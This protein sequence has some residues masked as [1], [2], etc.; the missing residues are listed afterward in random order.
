[1][2]SSSDML[3]LSQKKLF[4]LTKIS[5]F[6]SLY[7]D[8]YKTKWE[9][10]C[11]RACGLIVQFAIN[12][13]IVCLPMQWKY[14]SYTYTRA[15]NFSWYCAICIF[16]LILIAFLNRCIITTGN[17]AHSIHF[18]SFIC[19]ITDESSNVRIKNLL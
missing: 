17:I 8:Q 10:A 16:S 3:K 6:F 4:F 7:A 2:R 15:L 12:W 13:H 14:N 9:I 11:L 19:I 1:M 5:L 18:L